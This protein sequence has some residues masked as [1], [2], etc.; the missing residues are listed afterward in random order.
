MNAPAGLDHERRWNRTAVDEPVEGASAP[1]NR[2]TRA[3]AQLVCDLNGYRGLHKIQTLFWN[4]QGTSS[5]QNVEGIGP[6]Q[7]R[8]A[9]ST[10]ADGRCSTVRVC[11]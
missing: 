9:T 6:T 3:G 2:H 4:G 8:W 5:R 1:T 10:S 7:Q 11:E